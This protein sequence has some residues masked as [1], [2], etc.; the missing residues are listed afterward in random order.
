MI[1]DVRNFGDVPGQK[2]FH[3]I[4]LKGHQYRCQL[5][6]LLFYSR[7]N[8]S[9]PKIFDQ[10]ICSSLAVPLIN[11][12]RDSSNFEKLVKMFNFLF[13]NHIDQSERPRI[14]YSILIGQL[15]GSYEHF[16][17]LLQDFEELIRET[18]NRNE[19][20]KYFRNASIAT[21]RRGNNRLLASVIRCFLLLFSRIFRII[22]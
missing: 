10:F 20:F 19:F 21:E 16:K 15:T 12:S 8:R 4:L 22:N 2:K 5:L 18:A 3:H 6:D 17:E 7:D 14:R 9:V 11:S 1:F 13:I